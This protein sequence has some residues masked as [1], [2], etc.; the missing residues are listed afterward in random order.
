MDG[1]EK[2]THFDAVIVGSGFGGSVTTYRLAEADLRVCVLERG[3]AYPPNSFPR[4]P[5]PDEEQLLGPERRFARD[6]Q[7]LVVQRFGRG[8]L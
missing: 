3:K 8:R 7:H 1:N 5:T 4:S 2:G 6:V